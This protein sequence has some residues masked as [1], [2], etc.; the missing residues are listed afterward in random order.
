[1]TEHLSRRCLL[2]IMGA[3]GGTAI[4]GLL[5]PARIGRAANA[6]PAS[7]DPAPASQ[8]AGTAPQ[9][10]EKDSLAVALGYVADAKRVD[11]KASPQY[12]Q[13]ASCSGCSWYQGKP[14]DAT[15]PCTFF[16]GKRVNGQGWCRMWNKKS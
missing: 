3:A 2:A 1:M 6:A 15:A 7:Q 9:V 5:A 12:Q 4:L 13:G 11:A 8:D 14:T 10:D 16:P